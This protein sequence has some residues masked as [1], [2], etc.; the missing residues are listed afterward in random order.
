MSGNAP[1]FVA[2]KAR[3]L[4]LNLLYLNLL[5]FKLENYITIKLYN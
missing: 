1:N 5:K 3:G 4:N 2:S